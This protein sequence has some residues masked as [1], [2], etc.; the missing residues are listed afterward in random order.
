MEDYQKRLKNAIENLR[1]CNDIIEINKHYLINFLKYI[2]AKNL[3][4]SRQYKYLYT[5]KPIAIMLNKDFSLAD[6]NDI[7]ELVSK[8]NNSENYKENTKRD[9]KVIIKIFFKW[10]LKPTRH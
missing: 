1:H 5:L 2:S 3:S 7:I 4:L 10:F 6:K 9:F 8:I